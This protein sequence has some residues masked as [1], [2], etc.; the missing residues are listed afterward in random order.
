[1]SEKVRITAAFPTEKEVASRLRLSAGR[2]AELRKQLYDL[3]I[4]HPDGS[5]TVVEFKSRSGAKLASARK[6][7]K[8]TRAAAKRR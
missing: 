5:V 3:H 4:T 6:A 8:S 2:V 1:M 7:P